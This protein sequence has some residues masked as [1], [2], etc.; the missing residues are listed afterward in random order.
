[1]VST[2]LI[3]FLITFNATTETFIFN[4]SRESL[5]KLTETIKDQNLKIATVKQFDRNKN[6]FLKIPNQKLFTIID[7]H[8]ELSLLLNKNKAN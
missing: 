3:T 2:N 4:V 1:M 7:H 5:N 6:K 8:T